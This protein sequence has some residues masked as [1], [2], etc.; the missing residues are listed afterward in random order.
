M[1]IVTKDQKRRKK[2]LEGPLLPVIISI[3]APIF[4]YNFFNAFYSV[5]DA[6]IVSKI[7]ASS[8]SAVATLS[9]IKNLLSSLG[10][11]IASGGGIIVARLFGAGKLD[12]ARKNSNITIALSCIIVFVILIV[13]IPLAKPLMLLGGATPNIIEIGYGYFIIQVINLGFVFFNSVFIAMIKAKGNTK[14]ILILNL[15][16]MAIKLGLS[17]LF[18]YGFELKD[19]AW[20]AMATLIS[21]IM[22][23]IFLFIVMI[24]KNNAFQIRLNE[25][26]LKKEEVKKIIKI[27]FPIFFGKFI[28][29]F[30]KVSVN[31]MCYHYGELVVGA[32]GVSN[33]LCGVA[34]T[35]LNSFEE[36]TSTVVSQNLGNKQ[37]K[38]AIKAFYTSFSISLILGI[39]GYVLIRYA[40]Q[41][42]LINLY[43]QNKESLDTVTFLGLI[44]NINRFDSLSIIALA[45]NASVLG[46]LYGFGQTKLT[47]ILNISRVF[48]F[49]IPS[50]FIIQKCFPSI[51]AEAVGI[52]MCISNI[53]IAVTS[54][55]FLL[56]FLL[57]IKK[58]GYKENIIIPNNNK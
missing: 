39:V 5:A 32:L 29:S 35:P 8:V 25:I 52:S 53:G 17:I 13:C 38:R 23:F 9:Q 6:I 34:T 28:F 19:M 44:K 45:I 16:S 37:T 56:L 27:S 46:A 4:L 42:Q 58:K 30:G 18:V 50:L 41:D 7:G 49:R 12:E 54:I 22:M 11:G 24:D 26:R 3:C 55:I 2:I 47:M 51:G 21:Q 43:N 36:T 10:A 15:V 57:H 1:E 14:I 33:D 31:K 48:V 40:F 20:I